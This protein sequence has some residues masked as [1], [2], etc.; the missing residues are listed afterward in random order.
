MCSGHTTHCHTNIQGTHNKQYTYTQHRTQ[1]LCTIYHHPQTS[2]TLSMSGSR[3]GQK[4]KVDVNPVNS[5]QHIAPASINA[6]WKSVN[7]NTCNFK[8][9]SAIDTR[10]GMVDQCMELHNILIL[11][12]SLWQLLPSNN[13]NYKNS[14]KTFCGYL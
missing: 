3:R 9:V 4:W 5:E 8:L 14:Y 2:S 12:L 1:M 7:R 13:A 11:K 10:F 6:P